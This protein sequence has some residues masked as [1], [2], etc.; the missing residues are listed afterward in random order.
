[1][2]KASLILFLLLPGASRASEAPEEQFRR[3]LDAAGARDYANAL[4]NFEAALATDPD[5]LRYANEYRQTVIRSKE[6]DR[7]LKFFDKLVT[8]HPNSANA[9]LNAGFALIDK[10]PV[11]GAVTQA[12]LANTALTRFTNS[13]KLQPTIVAL[14]TR[15]AD[16]LYWP[17]VFNRTPLGIADLEEALKKQKA[18]E[19]Q[20]YFFKTWVAL[21]DGYWK[22]DRIEKAV[23]IWKE[24]LKEFPGNA[25]LQ[26]RL[27]KGGDEL[28]AYMDDYYD[29]NKRV[30]T[31]VRFLWEGQKG[32]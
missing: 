17:R 15:G 4:S 27:N 19:K 21:G 25:D 22:L 24:G 6:Y 28:K 1:M 13:I 9:W 2:T 11:S 10:M 29:F 18:A 16:Y 20:N 12:I 32:H 14:Y 26:A 31:D 23:A 3:G 7:S 8:D 5:N 30:D